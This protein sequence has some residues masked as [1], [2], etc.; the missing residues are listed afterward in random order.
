MG[1][2]AKFGD[3]LKITVNGVDEEK[4]AEEVYVITDEETQ[5]ITRLKKENKVLQKAEAYDIMQKKPF[6]FTRMRSLRWQHWEM[7][8]AFTAVQR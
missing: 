8:Q 1:L 6:G 7:T 2:A 5:M 4:A 3:S